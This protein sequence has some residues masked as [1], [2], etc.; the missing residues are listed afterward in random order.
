MEIAQLS[1][2]VHTVC[3][4]HVCDVLLLLACRSATRIMILQTLHRNLHEQHVCL[5]YIM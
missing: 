1:L 3:A 5:Q 4:M 2:Q